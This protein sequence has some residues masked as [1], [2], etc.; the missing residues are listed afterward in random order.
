MKRSIILKPH[1]AAALA[2]GETITI[3]RAVKPQ[4]KFCGAEGEQ[5]DI[6]Q[7]GWMTD[8]DPSFLPVSKCNPFPLNVPLLGKE[9]WTGESDPATSKPIWD[10][11]GNAYKVLYAA[12][13]E[14][15]WCDDGDGFTEYNRDG[16]PKSPWRSSAQMPAWAVRTLVTLSDVRVRKPSDVTREDAKSMGFKGGHSSIPGYGFSAT[17][18]EH[19]RD[20]WKIKSNRPTMRP[21]WNLYHWSYTAT[22]TKKQ[23]A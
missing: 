21:E 15:V 4:P 7:W 23:P 20:Q 22:P 10:E 9:T 11:D 18:S 17:P 8:E 19:W 6:N 1:E 5:G 3:W 16:S 14:E 12:D 13:G 2:R